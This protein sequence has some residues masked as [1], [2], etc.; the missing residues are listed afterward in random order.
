MGFPLAMRVGSGSTGVMK[1]ALGS[2]HAGFGFKERV[3][4]L[5]ID[6]GHTPLDFGCFDTKPADYPDFVLPAAAAVASGRCERGIVFGGSGNG[7]AIAANKLRG[8]RCGVGWSVESVRL[9][10]AHNDANVLSLGGRLVN[11]ADLESMLRMF[12]ETPFDSGRHATRIA[13]LAALGS[14]PTPA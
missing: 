1:I 9:T 13:K 4:S 5:L 6:W 2:D 7:E 3:K 12:L 8:I 14:A 11:P 10:R